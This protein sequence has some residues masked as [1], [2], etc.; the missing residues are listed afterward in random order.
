[1]DIWLVLR[2]LMI[3]GCVAC[4]LVLA[5]AHFRQWNRW[6]VTTRN[7][8]FALAGWVFL[9]LYS[10][11][12]NLIQGSPG[13]TRIIAGL[14]VVCFTIRALVNKPA[15]PSPRIEADAV[16]FWKEKKHAE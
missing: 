11:I 15:K 13:G 1:M 14:L 9:G 8:W 5:T 7:H 4:L 3:V 12:E 6:N 10:A 16:N 2:I